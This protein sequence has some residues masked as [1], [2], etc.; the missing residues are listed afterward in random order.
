VVN[1]KITARVT[2]QPEIVSVLCAMQATAVLVVIFLSA[3]LLAA[4]PIPTSV[5]PLT[6]VSVQ[7]STLRNTTKRELEKVA[8]LC[9]RM[10]LKAPESLFWS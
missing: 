1:A 7:N 3:T 2:N 10:V 6:N 9:A 5:S 4:D 8:N